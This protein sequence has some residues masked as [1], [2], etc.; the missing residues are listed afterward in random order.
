VAGDLPDD[1]LRRERSEAGDPAWASGKRPAEWTGDPPVGSP[2]GRSS[3]AGRVL[4]RVAFAVYGLLPEP[5]RAEAE[6]VFLRLMR[7]KYPDE[8]WRLAGSDERGR[9]GGRTPTTSGHV[10]GSLAAEADVDPLGRQAAPG[11]DEDRVDH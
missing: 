4:A 11:E 5:A 9:R 8:A 1:P 2:R 7:D 10:G 3:R 6:R